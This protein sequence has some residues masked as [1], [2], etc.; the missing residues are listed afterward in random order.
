MPLSAPLAEGE[1]GVAPFVAACDPWAWACVVCAGEFCDENLELILVIHE[2]RRELVLVSGGVV[3]LPPFS[4]LPR[5]SNA[6]RFGLA[7]IFCGGVVAAT[8]AGR[9]GDAGLCTDGAG[10]VR[11]CSSGW[12]RE[13]SPPCDEVFGGASL[14]RPGDDGAC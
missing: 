8:G 5:L 3:P 12:A 11:C 4:V 1:G 7:G 10:S 13:G 9:G 14:V 6:G 2:F